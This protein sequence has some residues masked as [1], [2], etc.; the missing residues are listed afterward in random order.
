MADW[1]TTF[2]QGQPQNGLPYTPTMMGPQNKFFIPGI[3]PGVQA[4]GTLLPPSPRP[5]P[6][7]VPVSG[8]GPSLSQAGGALKDLA[9]YM[10]ELEKN[11]LMNMGEAAVPP[12]V[13]A[14]NKYL[15]PGVDAGLDFGKQAL[16][17][18]SP[19]WLPSWAGGGGTNRDALFG[20]LPG[21]TPDGR[22]LEGNASYPTPEEQAWWDQFSQPTTPDAGATPGAPPSDPLQ[23]FLKRALAGTGSS[24]GGVGP[25][26]KMNMPNYPSSPVPQMAAPE[27]F[28]RTKIDELLAKA[29]PKAPEDDLGDYG[30]AILLGMLQGF[31]PSGTP[32]EILG[33]MVGPGAAGAMNERGRQKADKKEYDKELA[34][35]YQALAGSEANI[36]TTQLERKDAA[37]ESE[38]SNAVAKRAD[39]LAK[40]GMQREDAY[41]QAELEM[42]WQQLG[43][44]GRQVAQGDIRNQLTAAGLLGRYGNGAGGKYGLWRSI[45]DAVKNGM[46]L[47]GVDM[48]SMRQ[49]AMQAVQ[50]QNSTLAAT[51]PDQ[52]DMMVRQTMAN[53]LLNMAQDKPDLATGWQQMYNGNTSSALDLM[54]LYGGL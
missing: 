37:R 38:F 2:M 39:E 31:D 35:Y 10:W 15:R 5:A 30:I 44:Q 28:D 3:T 52:F 23:D 6:G 20:G 33:R 40:F 34:A 32:G 27:Q 24:G 26:P 42:Q 1:W 16:D 51:D 7:S 48:V 9:P 54:G 25:M 29:Q 4:L 46:P 18:P 14:Y 43:L 17:A 49:Q 13:D 36:Q 11:G 22:P 12:V 8:P 50:A 41:K 45:N 21:Y 19:S 47:P 53:M